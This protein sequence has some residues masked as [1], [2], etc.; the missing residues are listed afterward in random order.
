MKHLKK[1]TQ[2]CVSHPERNIV[3]RRGQHLIFFILVQKI[4]SNIKSELTNTYFI[5]CSPN[6][7]LL[8]DKSYLSFMCD[9]LNKTHHN[10]ANTFNNQVLFI[11]RI[12]NIAS[13]INLLK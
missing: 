6:V 9:L 4:H 12:H 5:H 10:F 3:L 11:H 2:C 8:F 7:L 13:F 1:M